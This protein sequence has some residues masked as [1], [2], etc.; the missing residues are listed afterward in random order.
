M[1][2]VQINSTIKDEFCGSGQPI[3]NVIASM[4]DM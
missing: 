1:P 4:G 2:I 3:T